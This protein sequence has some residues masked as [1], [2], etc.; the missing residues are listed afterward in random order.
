[1]SGCSKALGARGSLAFA[2]C[3][4]PFDLRMTDPL[5]RTLSA[6]LRLLKPAR[7][8]HPDVAQGKIE[9]DRIVRVEATQRIRDIDRHLPPGA[10]VAR[11]LQAASEANDVRVERDDQTLG[12]TCDQT[13]RS[14]ASFRTIQRR[15][16][17]SRLHALPADGRGKK[18][19]TPR[20]RGT[21]RP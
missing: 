5:Q 7:I 15:K 19:E 1:M 18:Y 4:L 11:Q 3:P 10:R 8:H 6:A 21:R 16:R 13:P 14:I 17:L 9:A 12:E 2:P 20:W